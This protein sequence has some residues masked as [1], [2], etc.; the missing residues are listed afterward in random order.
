MEPS[1]GTVSAIFLPRTN[2]RS[3]LAIMGTP[4]YL[5]SRMRVATIQG[6]L[7]IGVQLLFKLVTVL[8]IIAC[9]NATCTCMYVTIAMHV[10]GE[11]SVRVQM[12]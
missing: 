7:L 12:V 8:V 2:D 11:D 9:K 3:W 4:T 10:P 1:Q 5:C 6:R